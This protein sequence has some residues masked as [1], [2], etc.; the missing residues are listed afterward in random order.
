MNKK[1]LLG[2]GLIVLV[3]AG[4]MWWKNGRKPASEER[5]MVKVE[6]GNIEHSIAATGNIQPQ[7]RLEIKSPISGRIEKIM[8]VEGQNVKAGDILVQL[9]STERAALLDAARQQGAGNEKEWEDVYKPT[10]LIAPIDA[11][12]IVKSVNPGQTISS[13][14]P[15]I[16]LSDRLI[17]QAQVDETDIGKVKL[18]QKAELS[19]DAY[20]DIAV[21]GTVDHVYYESKIVNNVTIY[22][23]DIVPDKV[24]DVFRS[25]MSA[26]VEIIQD[27]REHVLL[28]P[29]EAVKKKQGESFVMLRREGERKPQR[30]NVETGISDES[31]IEIVSGLREG[32]EV[33]VA[34]A[35]YTP[36]RESRGT[37]SP[38]MPGGRGGGAGR[39]R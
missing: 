33:A 11:Q 18:G 15:V 32:D 12:V 38:F 8:V 26:N 17:V 31:N 2:V 29:R 10:S 21:T 27:R 30:Q 37:S 36:N 4:F 34:S 20:P 9:S 16:V 19:L 1:I 22:A 3:G 39:G 35:K 13:A 24:P 23:V 7:N 25:G 28:V 14:D 6:Y 5:R